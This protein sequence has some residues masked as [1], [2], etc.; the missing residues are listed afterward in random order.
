MRVSNLYYSYGNTTCYGILFDFGCST[1][2]SPNPIAF[3][4]MLLEIICYILVATLIVKY[5][6]KK[7]PNV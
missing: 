5:I 7:V 3:F 2:C 6:N 4:L 1:G